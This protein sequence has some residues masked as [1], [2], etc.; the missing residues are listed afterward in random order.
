MSALLFGS[1]STVA[2]TSELQR[3]A[4]NRG[5]RG[6]RPGLDVGP[7]R[8]PGHAGHQRRPL[9]HR[10]VRRGP[11][12]RRSTPQAVHATKSA[13]FRE[14]LARRGHARVPASSTP[15]TQARATGL[16]VGLVTTTARGERRRA[17]RG[18]RPGHRPRRLRRGRRLLPGRP[19]QAG[20]GRV[21]VR[22]AAVGRGPGGR[23][24]VE[25]NVG[26]VR[27]AV[28]AGVTCVAF[29]NENT[30]GHDFPG[31]ARGG[32]PPRPGRA[33]EPDDRPV[34]D[35]HRHRDR[36][37]RRGLRED[38]LLAALRRRRRSASGTPS[39][40]TATGR[41]GAASWWSTR[42]CTTSTASRCTPT[43]TT[44]ASR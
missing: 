29:P 33:W 39:S 41:S 43:S 35:V 1:I 6:A 27:S 23:V 7:R 19:A 17:A 32:R 37:P 18:A 36:L 34:A 24:A 42:R 16:K 11:R 22:A 40:P 31:A 13:F 38:R 30:A 25:D 28:A 5:V 2:D 20:R 3:A 26:G 4:F 8:L 15:S 14:S 44:T 12:R 10:R 9:T 21:R